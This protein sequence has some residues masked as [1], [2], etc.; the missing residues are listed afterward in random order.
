MHR[1]STPPHHAPTHPGVASLS[2]STQH[3]TC[4]IQQPLEKVTSPE[5]I[6]VR[7]RRNPQGGL[8]GKLGCNSQT[9]PTNGLLTEPSRRTLLT[10]RQKATVTGQALQVSRRSS[11]LGCWCM[12]RLSLFWRRYFW[13]TLDYW[14]DGPVDSAV[15]T[16]GAAWRH[17]MQRSQSGERNL[18]HGDGTPLQSAM[19]TCRREFGYA[20]CAE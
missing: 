7:L 9:H 20:L 18:P 17:F 19:N 5:C 6:I 8:G 14:A 12:T 4:S 1:N 2:A 15:Y 10:R 16:N 3:T 13:T 11:R